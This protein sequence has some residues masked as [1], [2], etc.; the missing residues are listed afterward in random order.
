MWR[1][2]TEN[3]IRNSNFNLETQESDRN[4]WKPELRPKSTPH[5]SYCEPILRIRTKPSHFNRGEPYYFLLKKQNFSCIDAESNTVPLHSR[6]DVEDLADR[7]STMAARRRTEYAREN[8]FRHLQ[9]LLRLGWNSYQF[10]L[11][12]L[13]LI[14]SNFAFTV[15]QLENQDPDMQVFYENV[16]LAYT[17]IFTLGAPPPARLRPRASN[18]MRAAPQRRAR[19]RDLARSRARGWIGGGGRHRQA[20]NQ[21]AP[22]N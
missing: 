8:R 14:L 21:G 5:E 15:L 3:S 16:D 1:Q 9:K 10:N 2:D 17:I 12:V 6:P 22:P 13:L 7:L 20:L 19:A 4:L 11:L 18:S